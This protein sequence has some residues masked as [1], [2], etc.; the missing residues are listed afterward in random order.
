MAFDALASARKPPMLR[1]NCAA[2]V[3][4]SEANCRASSGSRLAASCCAKPE[5]VVSE[6]A[7]GTELTSLDGF[8]KCVVQ[9]R[10]L[11]DTAAAGGRK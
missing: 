7:P 11:L 6:V 5:I 9:A 4:I 8:E 2:S 3:A 10:R 1:S